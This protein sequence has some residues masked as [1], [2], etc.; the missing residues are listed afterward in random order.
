TFLSFGVSV[1]ETG[2]VDGS[3]YVEHGLRPKLTFGFK[4]DADMTD[5]RMDDGTAY[6]FVRKPIPTGTRDFKL[7]YQLAIGS[8]LGDGSSPLLRSG[9]SF[10][11]SLRMWDRAGWLAVDTAAEWETDSSDLTLKIDGT[12]GL[13]LSDR[14]QVMMQVFLSQTNSTLSTTLAPSLIWHPDRDTTTR[15]QI[16][17]EAQSSMVALK[18]G[19]WREF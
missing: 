19:L 18:L 13:T 12:F 6:V 4:I 5:G 1:D 16:G 10:G 15:Y 14:F 7:A 3:I 17:L 2:Q 9:L 8:T 11:R